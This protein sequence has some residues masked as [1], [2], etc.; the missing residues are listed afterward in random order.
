M[1]KATQERY[2]E[3][4]WKKMAGLRDI[5][6]HEYF[7]IDHEIVWDIALHHLP[8]LLDQITRILTVEDAEGR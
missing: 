1:P 7:G 2:P 4:E 8:Q 5:V 6:I 3:V